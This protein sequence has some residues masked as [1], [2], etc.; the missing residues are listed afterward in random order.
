MTFYSAVLIVFK[1][2]VLLLHIDI[3][4]AVNNPQDNGKT[5]VFNRFLKARVQANCVTSTLWLDGMNLLLPDSCVRKGQSPWS[6]QIVEVL[7]D[8]SYRLLD[9]NKWNARRIKPWYS[10]SNVLCEAVQ[11]PSQRVRRSTRPVFSGSVWLFCAS[12]EFGVGEILSF[13]LSCVSFLLYSLL[14]FEFQCDHRSVRL[15]RP[16]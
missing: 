9:G 16:V 10:P 4:S 6:R 15:R 12:V 7:G 14:L 13:F 5:E 2:K 3:S 11:S 8:Y 1:F